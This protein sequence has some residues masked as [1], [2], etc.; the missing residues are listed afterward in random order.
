MGILL[1]LRWIRDD[2][3]WRSLVVDENLGLRLVCDITL[4]LYILSA[5]FANTPCFGF[6]YVLYRMII[7]RSING[8]FCIDFELLL[9][10]SEICV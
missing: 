6:E 8:S 3:T 5:S 2:S 10:Q 1:G 9:I 7:N 4:L